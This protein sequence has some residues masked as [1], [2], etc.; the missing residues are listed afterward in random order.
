MAI[1][2]LELIHPRVYS[3]DACS[4]AAPHVRAKGQPRAPCWPAARPPEY[5]TR[6]R[7]TP[8]PPHARVRAPCPAAPCWALHPSYVASTLGGRRAAGI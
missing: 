6:R 8:P 3:P 4:R 5:G 1:R 7:P 2:A